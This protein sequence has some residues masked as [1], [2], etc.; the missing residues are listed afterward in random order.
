MQPD[1][2]SDSLLPLA[3]LFGQTTCTLAPRFGHNG[4]ANLMT[5]VCVSEARE[6]IMMVKMDGDLDG[7]LENTDMMATFSKGDLMT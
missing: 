1:G 4:H 3:W 6:L 5:A 2:D 7:L